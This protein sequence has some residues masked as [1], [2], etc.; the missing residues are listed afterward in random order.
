MFHWKS[1]QP[2]EPWTTVLDGTSEAS[3]PIQREYVI[4]TVI[5]A[6]D[7][8]FLNVFTKEVTEGNMYVVHMYV[9]F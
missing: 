1:P 8:L 3:K 6:E 7:C 2:H 9:S 5:G 4:E